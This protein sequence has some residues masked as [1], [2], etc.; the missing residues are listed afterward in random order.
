MMIPSNMV[1]RSSQIEVPFFLAEREGLRN[2][3]LG[4]T[5]L[6][7][8]F[9]G[10]KNTEVSRN[11]LATKHK[12]HRLMAVLLV[13]GGE[14]GIRTLEPLLTVTRFPIV[15]ARPATRL[16]QLFT[17]FLEALDYYNE[18]VPYCQARNAIFLEIL[19]TARLIRFFDLTNGAR[20]A[21]ILSV[22]STERCP[23]GLR[24][25]S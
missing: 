22:S 1:Q 12:K 19:K 23:S 2:P 20:D 7:G 18:F 15:R 8:V 3:E 16:L 17:R 5:D 10:A 13:F 21:R 25:W 9:T 6:I 14:G 24:S 4:F 11:S